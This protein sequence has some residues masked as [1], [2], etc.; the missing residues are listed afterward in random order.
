MKTLLKEMKNEK[1][2]K[3]RIISLVGPCW[4]TIGF[5]VV[6]KQRYHC[7]AFMLLLY[8][9]RVNVSIKKDQ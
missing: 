2:A 5:Q 4:G 8:K 6:E 9:T 3:G 7:L 1:V